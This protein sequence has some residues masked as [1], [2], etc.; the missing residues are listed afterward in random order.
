[1][2]FYNCKN[3]SDIN[4]P[5]KVVQIEKNVFQN[6]NALKTI[7]IPDSVT[8]IGDSAFYLCSGLTSIV[9]PDT[10][11]SIGNGAFVD[12]RGLTSVTIPAEAAVTYVGAYAFYKTGISTVTLNQGLTEIGEYAFAL[13]KL[14][15]ISIPA[16]VEHIRAY[17]LST[18][19]LSQ[20]LFAEGTPS[21]NGLI[22]YNYAFVGT[23]ISE[24][25]LPA[26]LRLIGE[27]NAE[28]SYH[29][30]T[31]VFY[32]TLK[33]PAGMT[34]NTKLAKIYMP[35]NSKYY[36]AKDGI[37]YTKNEAGDLT[38]LQFSP[39]GNTAFLPGVMS[40]KKQVIPMLSDLWG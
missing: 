27:F 37:L 30:V 22:I 1:M 3:L 23:S 12:C 35:D 25:T 13:T 29:T 17:A 20:I 9:I 6:C 7:E 10:V 39:K 24:I 8:T 33:I 19:T 18:G 2:N 26:H 31:D 28:F 14:T 34:D 4:I 36:G 38:E 15:S 32:Q 40:R 21:E 11:T 5:S 16:S